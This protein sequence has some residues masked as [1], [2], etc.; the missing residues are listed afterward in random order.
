MS[1]FDEEFEKYL[2]E[3]TPEGVLSSLSESDLTEDECEL[4][5]VDMS[6]TVS[7]SSPLR[8]ANPPRICNILATVDLKTKID[9]KLIVQKAQNVRYNQKRFPGVFLFIQN[10]QSTA[11]LFSTGKMVVVG[12]QSVQDANIAS[13][14]FARIVQ[15]ICGYEEVKFSNFQ[16]RHIISVAD[17]G[18]PVN[19]DRFAVDH[20]NFASYEPEL[21]SALIYQ[22]VQEIPK[23][24]KNYNVK[25]FIYASG[26]MK[27][28]SKHIE[29]I[30][31][32]YDY[33]L[34][35]LKDYQVK[36]KKKK[37][38]F[39]VFLHSFFFFLLLSNNVSPLFISFDIALFK[40]LL[41]IV[42]L[43]ILSSSIS[44]LVL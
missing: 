8:K 44:F 3:K 27:I 4:S 6:P 40:Y 11:I 16:I 31:Y 25:S 32:L 36:Y 21:F 18:F 20:K 19:L 13:R 15:K 38:C 1:F 42:L 35:I 30:S 5:T 17:V 14:R 12:T 23:T 33:L 39:L 9:C 10:P 7:M 24:K 34:E 2:S 22:I 28:M 29:G 41:E 37:L 26:K 43:S